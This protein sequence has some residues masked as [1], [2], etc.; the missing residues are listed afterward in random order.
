MLVLMNP[1]N[2]QSLTFGNAPEREEYIPR[3]SIMTNKHY[4]LNIDS[5]TKCFLVQDVQHKACTVALPS[6][7]KLRNNF[8]TIFYQRMHICG[9]KKK[10]QSRPSNYS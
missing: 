10:K 9:E 7:F 1:L 3:V 4:I 2:F 6:Y 8:F 5:A